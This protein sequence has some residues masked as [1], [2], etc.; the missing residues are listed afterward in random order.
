MFNRACLAL[1]LLAGVFVMVLSPAPAHAMTDSW[2]DWAP[3][4]GTSNDY[5]TTMTQRSAGFPEAQM[6]SDSRANV[7]R[8]SGASTFLDANT[9][10]GAKYGSSRGSAYINLRPKADTP[11]GA[12]TTTYTFANPTPDT[13]W[14]FVLGD[15][16]SDQVRIQATDENGESVPAAAISAWF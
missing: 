6:A 11:S 9:P 15:I 16:D 14:A 12:S 7:A 10:P 8:P 4:S 2:A 1:V 5:S 3:I 13:G